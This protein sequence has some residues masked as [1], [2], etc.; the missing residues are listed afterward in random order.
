MDDAAYIA[1]FSCSICGKR[2][3][4]MTLARD[5]EEEH[6]EEDQCLDT[7]I[8]AFNVILTTK[9]S[10]ASLRQ[11]LDIT[12]TNAAT[13]FSVS[14]TLSASP[15]KVEDSTQLETSCN[16]LEDSLLQ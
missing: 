4:V 10:V 11:I 2:Y 1:K 13:L 12:A 15:L 8:R 14:L 5:C 6:M 16:L 9:K 7:N 3:V